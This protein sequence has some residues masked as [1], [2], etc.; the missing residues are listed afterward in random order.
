MDELLPL[1]YPLD[2]GPKVNNS[3]N[4]K[5]G[6]VPTSSLPLSP[7]DLSVPCL[8]AAAADIITG[9]TDKVRASG[10]RGEIGTFSSLRAGQSD[11]GGIEER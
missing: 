8:L 9:E 10:G 2:G 4:A 7:E 5:K 11:F 3:W 6:W 1:T